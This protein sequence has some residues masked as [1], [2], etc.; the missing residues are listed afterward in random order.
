MPAKA[1]TVTVLV[2]AIAKARPV[3]G[4]GLGGPPVTV[5]VVVVDAA[6]EEVVVEVDVAIVDVVVA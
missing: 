6:V 1:V 2:P 5:V 4:T 3:K